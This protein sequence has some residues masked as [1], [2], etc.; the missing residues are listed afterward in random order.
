MKSWHSPSTGHIRQTPPA[1][2]AEG[3]VPATSPHR[4]NF[5]KIQIMQT[6]ARLPWTPEPQTPS[7]K[8]KWTHLHQIH[9]KD[10]L[11]DSGG[12]ENTPTQAP[13]AHRPPQQPCATSA[14]SALVPAPWPGGRA[15]LVLPGGQ[16]SPAPSGATDSVGSMQAESGTLPGK[17][18]PTAG[19]GGE[20]TRGGS[21]RNPATSKRTRVLPEA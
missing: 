14:A 19:P 4:G 9:H 16:G 7:T 10:G 12:S 3:A 1:A 20:W 13:T 5:P 11:P 17:K 8:A 2:L 21:H 18:A 15:D 6:E